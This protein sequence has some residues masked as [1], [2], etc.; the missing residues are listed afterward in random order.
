MLKRA[1]LIAVLSMFC[2]TAAFA[3]QADNTQPFYGGGE[4]T[5]AQLQ[6][7]KVFI[8]ELTKKAGSREAAAK[9]V[10]LR[11]WELLKSGDAA[12]AMKRFNQAWLLT[13][14]DS[15]VLWGFAAAQ[16]NLGK[17]D[18]G[19]PLFERA[20]SQMPGNGALLSDYA[21]AY[22]SKAATI[23]DTPAQREVSF[24]RA[25][26]LLNQ[27]EALQPANPMIHSNRAIVRFFQGRYAEAWQG[28]EKAEKL[29]PGSVD[30]RFLRDLSAKMPRPQAK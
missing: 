27:A 29:A 18:V 10:L 15:D 5:P 30:Q 22:I 24:G 13:P 9:N 28:V 26:S 23:D 20:N 4:R 12:T 14:N 3:A 8:E 25:L 11:G 21:Y 16:C 1:A 2:A 6:A 17:F 19:L 7:D